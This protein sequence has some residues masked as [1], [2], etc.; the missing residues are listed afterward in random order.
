M[1]SNVFISYSSKDSSIANAMCHILEENGILCWIAPRD[2]QLGKPYAGEIVSGIRSCEVVIIIFSRNSNL[3]EHV[4]NEIDMAFN[5]QKVIVPFLVDN[6]PMR[7]EVSYYLNRKHWLVAYPDYKEKFTELLCCIKNILGTTKN[8]SSLIIQCLKNENGQYAFVDDN[9]KVI[10]YYHFEDAY[11]FYEN[12]AAVK[13]RGKWGFVDKKGEFVISPQYDDV[14]VFRGGLARV[15]LNNKWGFINKENKIIIPIKYDKCSN[16]NL[17]RTNLAS[18][19][20]RGSCFFIN[21]N[22]AS[23]NY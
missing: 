10:K 14:D 8:E 4:V 21:K 7:D 16:F 15:K 20:F 17:Y 13:A 1:K 18:V 22:G 12:L 2:V 5:E 9:N 23:I 3:S 19:Y 11:N 6:T